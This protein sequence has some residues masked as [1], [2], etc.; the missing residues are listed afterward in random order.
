MTD[1]DNLDNLDNS[2]WDNLYLIRNGLHWPL[3]WLT[4]PPPPYHRHWTRLWYWYFWHP[5]GPDYKMSVFYSVSPPQVGSHELLLR[6]GVGVGRGGREANRMQ[7]G[8]CQVKSN[9][10]VQS[11]HWRYCLQRENFL[12]AANCASRPLFWYWQKQS[13]VTVTT[14]YITF[15]FPAE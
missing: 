13:C 10:R 8:E 15:I 5:W 9:N 4:T 1:L 11:R 2:A 7:H 12:S 14:K 6:V 3:T